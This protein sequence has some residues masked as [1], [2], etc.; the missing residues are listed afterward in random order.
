MRQV[1]FLHSLA[2]EKLESYKL[3]AQRKGYTLT[4]DSPVFIAYHKQGK[5]TALGARSMNPIFDEGSL[6]AWHDLEV[7]RFS[8]HDFR[9]YLQS[10]L[11][12]ANINGNMISPIL[13][14]KVK[15]VDSHYSN[16][17]KEEM[18]EKYR[19]ALPYLL[20]QSVE[21]LKAEAT[22]TKE[23]NDKCIKFLEQR[24]LDNGL[25]INKV[26]ANFTEFSEQ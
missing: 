22:E 15:G 18:K 10:A 6:K 13:S 24:L 2:V 14:H 16:H 8:P 1:T 19:S 25:A 4:D 9:D 26:I 12:S 23:Q 20:P 17:E 3:E 11:E 7:K 21:K 5:I